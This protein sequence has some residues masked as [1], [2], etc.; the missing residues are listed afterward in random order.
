M[1]KSS[2][3]CSAPAWGCS[4]LCLGHVQ[5]PVLSRQGVTSPCRG[6][7]RSRHPWPYENGMEKA[8][9]GAVSAPEAPL[10]IITGS[11][12]WGIYPY[13]G[14]KSGPDVGSSRG[15]PWSRGCLAREALDANTLAGSHAGGSNGGSQFSGCFFLSSGCKQT[16]SL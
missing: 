6:S 11:W 9:R 12:E 16:G 4:G 15:S 10:R 1:A 8:P 5:D 7:W 13:T 14:A 2:N 3:S